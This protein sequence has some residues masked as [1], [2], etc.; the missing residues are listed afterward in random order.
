MP[1]TYKEQE[2]VFG[3]GR[4]IYAGECLPDTKS[5][6]EKA[7]R[8][9]HKAYRPKDTDTASGCRGG[10]SKGRHKGISGE[11]EGNKG[12]PGEKEKEAG[13]GMRIKSRQGRKYREKNSLGQGEEKP[14]TDSSEGRMQENF[15][16]EQNLFCENGGEKTGDETEEFK[17]SQGRKNSSQSRGRNCWTDGEWGRFHGRKGHIH[18]KAGAQGSRR[19]NHTDKGKRESG[20]GNKEKADSQFGF[21]AE[22]TSHKEKEFT[23]S[24]KLDRLQKEAEKAA[25][26]TAKARKKLPR[27]REYVLKRVFDE[28][29]GRG[30]DVLAAAETEK[31]FLAD[32]GVKAAAGR[33]ARGPVNFVHRKIA[34]VEKENSAVEGAHKAEQTAGDIFRSVKRHHGNKLQRRRKKVIKLEKRQMKKEA[35]FRYQKFLEEN[36]EMQEKAMKRM[37]RKRMQKQRI[38]REYARA[39]RT[40]QA[41]GFAKEAYSGTAAAVRKLQEAAAEHAS[42][43]VSAGALIILLIMVITAVSSCAALFSEGTGSTLAGAYM[44]APAEIDAVELAFSK[45]EMELQ[46]ALN[47]IE[48]DYPDYDEYH[49]DLDAIGHDPFVLISFLSAIHTEFTA[50]EVQGDVRMLFDELYDL[51]LTP[52]EAARTRTVIKTGTRTVTDPVTGAETEEEYEY[53]E[54]EEYTAAVLEVVLTAADFEEIVS[55]H[56]DD[57]QK[58]VYD[59]CNAAHG[60]VQQFYSPVGMPWHSM[61][62]SYYGYRIHPISGAEQFHRGVDI[63]VPTGTAVYAA[64]DG[65]VITAAYDSS[66]GNYVAIEDGGYCTI[67]AHMDA[68]SVSAGQAVRHGD[69]IGR[70]G[71]TGNSTGSHLHI[72]CMYNGEYYNPLFYFCE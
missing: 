2:A 1:G 42:L 69:E 16:K 70:S 19:R 41:A 20:G 3:E 12:S 57:G 40:K 9:K 6:K 56:M 71:S 33:A 5:S 62:S 22:D 38:K 30:K 37:R 10:H 4:S 64:M 36:P 59:F 31:T 48:T 34:E 24:K 25:E 26:R 27:K 61:V 39:G 72:E 35:G 46:K 7:Q 51:T 44:S 15:C 47:S 66:Y 21:R 58:A 17:D 8:K 49:Y 63:A 67:Y 68:L 23:G 45:L 53:E 29:E 11:A 50:A 55:G 14:D 54:E 52:S 18:Q 32:S 13:A 43:F 28:E 60:L 65:I